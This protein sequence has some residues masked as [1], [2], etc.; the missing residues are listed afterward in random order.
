[1]T[2]SPLQCAI[3]VVTS[4]EVREA[5]KEPVGAIIDAVTRTLEKTEPELSADLVDNGITMAGGSLGEMIT[6]S[7]AR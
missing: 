5:L 6:S 4:E 2:N 7:M 3:P 1:M